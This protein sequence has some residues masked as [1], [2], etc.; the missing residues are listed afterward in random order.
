MFK[1]ITA[2]L[3]GVVMISAGLMAVS[4]IEKVQASPETVSINAVITADNPANIKF[5]IP[6]NVT[7]TVGV[8]QVVFIGAPTSTS[9]VNCSP[10]T[11]QPQ[12]VVA[13]HPTGGQASQITGLL[14]FHDHAIPNGTRYRISAGPNGCTADLDLYDA[15]LD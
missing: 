5:A 9:A 6:K 3:V 14:A 4:S 2:I 11:P 12:S 7:V 1:K 8:T 15:V 10:G 13:T